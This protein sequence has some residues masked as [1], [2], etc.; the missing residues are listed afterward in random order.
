MQRRTCVARAQCVV[1]A[2]AVEASRL[3]V[4]YLDNGLEFSKN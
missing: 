4:L 3:D 1:V 2:A